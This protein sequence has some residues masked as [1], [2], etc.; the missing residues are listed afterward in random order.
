LYTLGHSVGY[1]Q[2]DFAGRIANRITQAGAA[3][4]SLAVT[5]LDT[6]V[7]VAIFAATALGLF[8]SV[9]L[10]LALPMALW[11]VGYVALLRY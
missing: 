7:Y 9:S 4:R 2:T 1:F 8:G 3:I 5:L 10:W 6:L 11:I